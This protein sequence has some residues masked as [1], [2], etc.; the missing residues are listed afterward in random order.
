[1]WSVVTLLP[2]IAQHSRSRNIGHRRRRLRHV[3]EV[4]RILHVGRF[5]VP[6]ERLALGN[7]QSAPLRV[8]AEHIFIGLLEQIA[9]NELRQN[10]GHFL[11]GRPDV[12][13]E[14]RLAFAI[15]QRL[16][17]N[18]HVDATGQ[19]K[20]HHQRRRHQVVRPH[21][22]VDAALEVAIAAQHRCDHQVLVRDHARYFSGQR[23]RIADARRA[24]IAHHV[25]LQLL[26]IRQQPRTREVLSHYHRS[27]RQR[28][29]HPLG[30]RQSLLY[31]LLCQQSCRHQHRRIRR[32]SA[33]GNRGDHYTAVSQ[34]LFQRNFCLDGHRV[35]GFRNR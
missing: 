1:M 24:S 7:F 14:D 16:V 19:G 13:E 22:G 2:R 18:I 31:R 33:T 12:F 30:N 6:G 17:I 27:R 8:A 29:L 20:R 32:V 34:R 26:E 25:E 3:L 28:G 9:G 10:V 15:A 21:L 11:R 35:L 4:R 23:S 5:V